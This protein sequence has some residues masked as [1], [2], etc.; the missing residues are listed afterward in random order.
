MSIKFN[1]KSIYYQIFIAIFTIIIFVVQLIIY[2]F[3]LPLLFPIIISSSSSNLTTYVH[4]NCYLLLFSFVGV[5]SYV[6]CVFSNVGLL[7]LLCNVDPGTF[8]CILAINYVILMPYNW[9]WENQ[10]V[11]HSTINFFSISMYTPRVTKQKS[12]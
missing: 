12:T 9:F 6:T 2:L 10:L 1:W 7:R 4:F 8:L 11:L 3:S 5:A